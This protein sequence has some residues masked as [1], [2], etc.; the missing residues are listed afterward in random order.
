M[1]PA[2]YKAGSVFFQTLLFPALFKDSLNELTS[3][4]IALYYALNEFG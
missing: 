1:E 4:L 3:K 2:V